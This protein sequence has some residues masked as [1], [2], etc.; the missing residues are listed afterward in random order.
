MKKPIPVQTCLLALALSTFALGVQISP[1]SFSYQYVGLR[2]PA[3]T[4]RYLATDS[5]VSQGLQEGAQIVGLDSPQIQAV[6]E[7]MPGKVLVWVSEQP[8]GSDF[9]GI[10]RNILVAAIDVRGH[11][12]EFASEADFLEAG[13]QVMKESLP[14]AEISEISVQ[15]LGGEDFH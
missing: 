7:Q 13:S 3:P 5:E 15:R 2:F 12:D 4:G 11:R 9:E 14:E 8:P 1:G 6:V 10:N